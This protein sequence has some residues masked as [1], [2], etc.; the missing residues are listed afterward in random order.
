[1]RFTV[2]CTSR[3]TGGMCRLVVLIMINAVIGGVGVPSGVRWP[4]EADS[5]LH[6]PVSRMTSHSGRARAM[7]IDSWGE[8]VRKEAKEVD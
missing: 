6:R 3:V 8:G 7:F 4:R 1:M 2:K 5:W